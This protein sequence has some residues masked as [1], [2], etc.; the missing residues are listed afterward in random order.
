MPRTAP[1]PG[2]WKFLIL[3]R[4]ARP[5]RLILEGHVTPPY[6]RP[7]HDA[8]FFYAVMGQDYLSLEV[9]RDFDGER[10]LEY[11]FSRLGQPVDPPRIQVGGRQDEEEGALLLVEWR[12]PATG[13]EEMIHRLSAILGQ[14]LAD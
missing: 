4:E 10:L 11:L 8:L 1:V 9:S 2:N 3:R 7:Y 12:F 14:S 5:R 13:R 6:E